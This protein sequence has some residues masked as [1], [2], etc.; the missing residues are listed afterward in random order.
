MIFN[1]FV[2]NQILLDVIIYV[3]SHATDNTKKGTPIVAAGV[4]VSISAYGSI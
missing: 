2:L 4:I 3:Q 1:K